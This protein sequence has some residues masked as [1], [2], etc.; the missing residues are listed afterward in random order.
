MSKNDKARRLVA[1]RAGLFSYM[2]RELTRRNEYTGMSPFVKDNFVSLRLHAETLARHD[3]RFAG[4]MA[5]SRAQ[6]YAAL[7][8]TGE[9]SE[10]ESLSLQLLEELAEEILGISSLAVEGYPVELPPVEQFILSR[11]REN[12]ERQLLAGASVQARESGALTGPAAIGASVGGPVLMPYVQWMLERS[13]ALGIKRLYFIARDGYIL[14]RIA[15]ILIDR[16]HLPVAAHYI[17]GSRRAWRMPSYGGQE[18]ELREL[19][20]WAQGVKRSVHSLADILQVEERWLEPYLPVAYQGEKG[21]DLSW[22]ELNACVYTLDKSPDFR[23]ALMDEQL[24]RRRLVQAYLQQEVDFSD[25]HFAFVELGGGGLTQICLARLMRDFCPHAITT[26]YYKLDRVRKPGPQGIFYDFF[27]NR[28]EH[29]LIMEMICR[30]PEGQTECYRQEDTKIVPVKKPGERERYLQH[31]YDKY[32]AG[33]E[34]FAEAYAYSIEKFRPSINIAAIADY[35]DF[36]FSDAGKEVLEFFAGTPNSV[37]GREKIVAD[38]APPLDKQAAR[39]IFLLHTDVEMERY[40]H[41]TDLELSIQRSTVDVQRRIKRYREHG[42]AICDRWQRF[43]S[44]EQAERWTDGRLQ[45]LPMLLYG[46]RVVLYGGGIRGRR[47]C[48]YL[49]KGHIAEIVQWLDK[50]WQKL[51]VDE[52]IP[53]SGD[54]SKLGDVPFDVVLIAVGNKKICQDIKSDMLTQNI[55]D[56]KIIELIQLDLLYADIADYLIV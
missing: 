47:I 6:V 29:H 37:S 24:T 3:C 13:Q 55:P 28:M 49:Q 48:E 39:N 22:F 12:M 18:G 42:L 16:L 32:V 11:G 27:P 23:K 51:K 2:Q 19:V 17:H 56:M 35:L 31:G 46:K 9:I 36:I 26:F 7:C 25:E 30:A 53:V 10:A 21:K 54:I 41:G 20:G 1:D 50:D 52:G 44:K 40:Y 33:I 34:A 8:L 45:V 15:D 14:K 43:F 38:F 5:P 4:Q